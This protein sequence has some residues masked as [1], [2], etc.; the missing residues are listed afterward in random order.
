MSLVRKA[1]LSSVTNHL[2]GN[3]GSEL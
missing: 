3:F 2:K 1:M